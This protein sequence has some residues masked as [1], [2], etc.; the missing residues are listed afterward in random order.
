M[1]TS[2]QSHQRL[3]V[4]PED[5]VAVVVEL[6]DS[7]REQLLLKQFKLQSEPVIEALLRAHGRG[8][9]VRVM[10]NP[11][12]SGGDRWNDDSFARLESSG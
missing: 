3:L 10:L 11:H 2:L 7:A 8:V 6:I 1:V 12:T 9:Q 5:G 4:M